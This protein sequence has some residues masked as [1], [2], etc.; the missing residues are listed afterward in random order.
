MTEG[1]RQ[2]RSGGYGWGWVAAVMIS[3]S[4]RYSR[5]LLASFVYRFVTHFPHLILTP[6][7]ERA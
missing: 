1:R 4:L 2:Q 6:R 7:S 5:S 3:S